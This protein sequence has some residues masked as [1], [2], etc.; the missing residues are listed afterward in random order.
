MAT[1]TGWKY[2]Y[3]RTGAVGSNMQVNNSSGFSALP[4][5]CRYMD[6]SFFCKGFYGEWWSST[7][8]NSSEAYHHRLVSD[9][10]YLGGGYTYKDKGYSIRLVRD[11]N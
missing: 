6:G 11:L 7:E 5:G 1:N 4:G 9:A 8:R 10:A 2:Y 3:K